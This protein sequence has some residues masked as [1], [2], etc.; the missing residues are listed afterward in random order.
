[1]DPHGHLDGV[2]P[3]TRWAWTTCPVYADEAAPA[4]AVAGHA[5]LTARPGGATAG[6]RV[7]TVAAGR[8]RLARRVRTVGI[9]Q[10]DETP[11]AAR[12]RQGRRLR[13][14]TLSSTRPASASTP[15]T[16]PS[17]FYSP[18]LLASQEE[19]LRA[20]RAL[21]ATAA[22]GVPEV[23]RAAEELMQSARRRLELFDVPAELPAAARA[24][25][26]RRSGPSRCCRTP[27]GYV[28]DEGRHRGAAGRAGRGAVHH[29]RPVAGVDRGRLLRER[30]DISCGSA[31]RAMLALPYDPGKRL[32]G[33]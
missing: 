13:R 26:G 30:G 11:R 12:A 17:S 25:R 14:E 33:R 22:C 24:H 10:V 18:E 6:R 20:R 28:T 3:R 8:E 21:A 27:R 9:V 19:Y 1:M 4:T 23:R 7:Q 5:T 31:D 29:Q 2:Q 16:R 32:A 15:A